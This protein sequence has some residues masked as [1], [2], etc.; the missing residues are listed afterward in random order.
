MTERGP[1][2]TQLSLVQSEPGV[3]NNTGDRAPGVEADTNN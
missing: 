3:R 1:P 2:E